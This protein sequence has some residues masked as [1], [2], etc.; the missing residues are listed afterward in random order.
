M[1]QVVS[2]VTKKYYICYMEVFIQHKTDPTYY[3]GD[4]GRILSFKSGKLRYLSPR[5]ATD[6]RSRV[7]IDNKE[8]LLHRLIAEHWCEKP[9]GFDMVTHIDGDVLNNC[10]INLQWVKNNKSK[11]IEKFEVENPQLKKG[12]RVVC[13]I[14]GLIYDSLLIGCYK[15]NLN[16]G[17]ERVRMHR[18]TDNRHFDFI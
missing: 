13:R 12:K 17:S 3:I 7:V 10:A 2:Y 1:L 15:H 18:K 4:M 14:T 8:V 16:Y 5:V 9:H 11:V 6:G